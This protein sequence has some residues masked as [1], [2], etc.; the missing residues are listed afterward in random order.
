M[1]FWAPRL[2]LSLKPNNNRTTTAVR[3]QL[4]CSLPA[5]DA[6]SMVAALRVRRYKGRSRGKPGDERPRGATAVV[7][8]RRAITSIYN[9]STVSE[10]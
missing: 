7:L 2:P 6:A 8:T 3:E 5:R 9:C 1:D 4:A 10:R